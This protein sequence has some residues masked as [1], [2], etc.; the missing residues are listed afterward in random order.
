MCLFFSYWSSA[1][2]S[3]LRREFG[4]KR[5]NYDIDI[6]FHGR[7][8]FS[9]KSIDGHK[10]HKTNLLIVLHFQYSTQNGIFMYPIILTTNWYQ[11]FVQH[12]VSKSYCVM[13]QTLISFLSFLQLFLVIYNVS[14]MIYL[15]IH[16]LGITMV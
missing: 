9:N 7:I 1:W 2:N 6:V 10:T 3:N 4:S 12:S 15:W 11:C 16:I 14:S 5:K 13:A 8:Y